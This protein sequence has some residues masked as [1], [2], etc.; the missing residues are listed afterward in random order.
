MNTQEFFIGSNGVFYNDYIL[1]EK[2][3]KFKDIKN[4]RERRKCYI[5]FKN[6]IFI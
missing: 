4:K 6:N 5:F 3:I 2:E 1:Y